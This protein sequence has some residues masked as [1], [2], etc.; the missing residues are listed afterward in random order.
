ML[1]DLI[2]KHRQAFAILIFVVIGFPMLFFGTQWGRGGASATRPKGQE[3]GKV[4]DVPLEAA[5]FQ[6]M[7]ANF[8]RPGPDGK[9]KTY[10]ELEADGTVK[11]ILDRM[12]DG[13]II[14]NLEKQRK[15]AVNKDLLASRL[16][17]LPDFKDEKGEFDKKMWNEWVASPEVNWNEIYA[18]LEEDVA[19]QVFIEMALA[20][21]NRVTDAELNKEIEQKFSSYKVKYYHV[22]PGVEPTQADLEATYKAGSEATGDR[23]ARYKK[24]DDFVVDYV[25]FPTVAAVP[26]LALDIV[27]QAREGGNFAELA[28]KH[29]ALKLKNG[30]E[31]NGW[32]RERENEPEQRKPLFALKAGEVSEPVAGA[33]GYYIYKVEEEQTATD[34]VREVKARQILVEAKLSDEERDAILAKAKDLS[35]KAKTAGSLAKAVEEANAA[36]AGLEIKRTPKFNR[37]SVGIEGLPSMDAMRFRTAFEDYSDE[38]KYEPIDPGKNSRAIYVSEL[39][40]RAPGA[41][42]PLDEIKDRV[43]KD[44]IRELKSKE[45]Y[46]GKAKELATKIKE[47]VK[48]IDE[49]AAKFPELKGA[50]A[51]SDETK[52]KEFILKI[53]ATAPSEDR[54]FIGTSSVI[55]AFK[56]AEPGAL[57]GPIAGLMG[58]DQYFLQLVERKP[59]T[60]E[61]KKEFDNERV[62]LRA[63]KATEAKNDLMQDLTQDLRDTTKQKFQVELDQ[64]VLGM[65]LDRDK[66]AESPAE[67]P[68]PAAAETSAPAADAPAP[69]PAAN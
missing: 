28:D 56:N 27:K 38:K 26:Q 61:D 1:Q 43:T 66:K 65:M 22:D 30:G 68:A 18:R 63:Q 37:E 51:E 12:I 4:G 7:I 49:I 14:T 6:R 53:P 41:V 33:S 29:S 31:M 17:E 24:P 59:P 10:A 23:P 40:E 39:V 21:A 25:A 9:E 11:K 5:D 35:E 20:P 13:A 45:P 69:A 62:S 64:T 15:F 3:I 57:A 46:I 60:D 16:K 52:G 50:V 44:A 32:Q 36:G 34:G 8:R 54:P 55:D 48:N 67:T 42:P 19:R 2:R 58:N 47:Q